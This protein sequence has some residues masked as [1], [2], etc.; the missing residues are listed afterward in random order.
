MVKRNSYN[1]LD[2]IFD[3]VNLLGS[4][5]K[6]SRL[7]GYG[8]TFLSDL[9]Q[10]MLNPKVRGYNPS[11][12]FSENSLKR[13]EINLKKNLGENAEKCLYLINKYKK[14][15]PN[16]NKYSNQQYRQSLN[17]KFFKVID[18]LEKAY[19][20]GFLNADGEVKKFYRGRPWYL[21]SI[22]LSVKDRDQLVRFCKALGLNPLK[23]IKERVRIKKYR[24]EWRHYRMA[25]IRFRCKPMV[26]D[27][28]NLGFSSSNSLRKTIPTIFN[29]FRH[30]GNKGPSRRELLLAWLIGYYDGDGIYNTTRISSSSK[31]FL[32]KIRWKFNIRY[33]VK[34]HYDSDKQFSLEGVI[35]KR[36]HWTLSLGMS[37]FKEMI[38][39]YENS[40][41]RKRN[42][43][44]K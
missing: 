11:Y 8:S 19:W 1:A 16:L 9:K 44:K 21:I 34:K 40:M 32:E 38:Q 14:N 10:R 26:G 29:Q 20:L 27:L 22:E 33:K 30:N 13:F 28:L 41:P 43:L 12:R 7:L 23:S 3:I 36:P 39:N 5:P 17:V 24:E 35:S 37:L 6:A 42:F 4:L 31:D 25:Y 18:I 2:F 15:N